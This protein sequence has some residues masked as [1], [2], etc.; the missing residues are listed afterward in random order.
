MAFKTGIPRGQRFVLVKLC[1]CANDEGLC[2]PS[3]ETVAEDTGFGETAVQQHIKWLKE[4][5]FIKSARRQRGRERQSDIY[6][7]NVALLEKCYAE[8]AKR[9]AERRA[10][11]REEPSD[12]EPS[13]FEPSDF[14]PSDFEPSDFE[15][16][17]FGSKNLQILSH[18]PSDFG[19]SLYEEPSVEPSVEPSGY[20]TAPQTAADTPS[21]GFASEPAPRSDFADDVSDGLVGNLPVETVKAETVQTVLPADTLKPAKPDNHTAANRAVWAAYRQAYL[22]RYG[23]EPLR[24]AKVNG[25]IAQFVRTV[26]AEDAPKLAAFYP[27]HNGGFFV[28]RRHDFGLLLQSAQQIRTDWLRGEQMTAARAR[29]TENTQSNLETAKRVLAARA[30]RRQQGESA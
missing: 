17:D 18:E 24:N 29:Q 12:F 13:D 10:K 19:G 3:Q 7:I 4:N 30:A 6:R 11:M 28:Q 15:P 20:C 1:D 26:G 25:Q 2:Y 14:E 21:C 22:D 9:K 27:W 5:N 8:A 16:S 23:V